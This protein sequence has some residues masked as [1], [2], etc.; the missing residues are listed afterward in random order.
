ME[1]GFRVNVT[2]IFGICDNSGHIYGTVSA[3]SIT[4]TTT[5]TSTT[6]T[7]TRILT[8]VI[9]MPIGT[10]AALNAKGEA[11]TLP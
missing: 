2:N 5:T 1:I 8:S 4:T 6:S 9:L 3:E 11:T 7:T 10:R